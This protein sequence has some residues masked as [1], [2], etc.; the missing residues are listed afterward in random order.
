M[1]SIILAVMVGV[2]YAAGYYLM[3]RRSIIKLIFGLG[4]ISHASNL[5]IFAAGRLTAGQP[6]LVHEGSDL[7]P[8]ML[9]DPLPQA[10]I[11][12]AIVI[13][14][15]VQ[16]FALVLIKCIYQVVRTDDLDAMKT[17]DT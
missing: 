14:F 6:P 1:E 3:M 13:G 15:G 9:A 12:T 17:T 10:L 5:L 8:E 7:P 16:A 4:M 11:L 2:F